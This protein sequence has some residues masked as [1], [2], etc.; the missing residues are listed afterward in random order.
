MVCRLAKCICEIGSHNTSESQLTLPA[1]L[2][3]STE[4]V[5]QNFSEVRWT[6]KIYSIGFLVVGSGNEAEM[7]MRGTETKILTFKLGVPVGET[8]LS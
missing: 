6:V 3:I 5:Q 1:H 2:C 8:I 7:V 4:V